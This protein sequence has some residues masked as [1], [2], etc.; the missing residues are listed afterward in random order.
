MLVMSDF[1]LLTSK[2]KWSETNSL[3][4]YI[5]SI[6]SEICWILAIFFFLNQPFN[7]FSICSE[8]KCFRAL[9]H[10]SLSTWAI[11]QS[12]KCSSARGVAV[13][14]VMSVHCFGPDWNVSTTTG[15]I[16]EL[17]VQIHQDRSD[18]IIILTW[19][20][21]FVSVTFPIIV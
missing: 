11:K 16:S 10:K 12:W 17:F 20:A 18:V 8:Q 15:W 19:L 3:Y 13:G 21:V 6:K 9:C 14:T 5:I 1:I 4:Y 2:T 7:H